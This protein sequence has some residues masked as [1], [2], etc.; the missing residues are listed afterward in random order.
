MDKEIEEKFV[1]TFIVK[2]KRKRIIFE[3]CSN[4]KRGNAIQKLLGG[5]D[6]RYNVFRDRKVQEDEFLSVINRYFDIN[7]TCYVIADDSRNDG[8]VLPFKTAY[9]YMMES[10]SVYVLVCG[11]NLIIAK[12]E[13]CYDTTK[14]I[15]FKS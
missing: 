15:Y 9:N 13:Y 6:D 2:E 1:N 10:G 7:K 5:L 14:L 12:E 3:L 4:K 8:T 11:D